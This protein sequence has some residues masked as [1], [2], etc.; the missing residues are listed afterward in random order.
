[1]SIPF[2]KH[3]AHDTVRVSCITSTCTFDQEVQ[4]CHRQLL[5]LY[6]WFDVPELPQDISQHEAIQNQ[7]KS[8]L[9]STQQRPLSRLATSVA[10]ACRSKLAIAII[11]CSVKCCHSLVFCSPI[12]AKVLPMKFQGCGWPVDHKNYIPQ[13]FVCS[14][15]VYSL[16]TIQ[17]ISKQQLA[18]NCNS[19][20]CIYTCSYTVKAKFIAH[21][22]TKYAS[23][24]GLFSYIHWGGILVLHIFPILK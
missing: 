7:L 5:L 19:I 18:L 20:E 10:A 23:F 3:V 9:A 16:T 6:L 1:M 2:T 17:K 15:T 13:K 12:E 21:E 8:M 14:Y 11:P 4:V 24:L 22:V